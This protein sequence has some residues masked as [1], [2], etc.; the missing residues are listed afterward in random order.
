MHPE[1]TESSAFFQQV[2]DTLRAEI[3]AAWQAWKQ[4]EQERWTQWEKIVRKAIQVHGDA[5]TLLERGDPWGYVTRVETQVL[6]P[7]FAALHER[8]LP[9][10][11]PPTPSFDTLDPD[12]WPERV[13]VPLEAEVFEKETTGWF[14]HRLLCRIARGVITRWNR[15]WPHRPWT[16]RIPL[17]KLLAFHLEV[18]VPCAWWPVY[19]ICRTHW[20]RSVG[21]IEE[22]LTVWQEKVLSS[23]LI[24]GEGTPGEVLEGARAWQE[25]LIAAIQDPFPEL[26]IP[27]T[28]LSEELAR[29]LDR[30][31]TFLL[32]GF[33][34]RLPRKNRRFHGR[35]KGMEDAW[36]QWFQQTADRVALVAGRVQVALALKTQRDR[37]VDRLKETLRTPY[38]CVVERFRN[39]LHQM[40]KQWTRALSDP[41]NDPEKLDSHVKEAL[42]TREGL[43]EILLG[44]LDLKQ[45]NAVLDVPA[46]REWAEVVAVLESLPEQ[47]VLHSAD[48][49]RPG[50][51]FQTLM[52]R[53]LILEHI[54]PPWP[55]RLETPSSHLRRAILRS[56]SAL[57][58]ILE[59]VGYNLEAAREEIETG[60]PPENLRSRLEELVLGSLQSAE[61]RLDEST[62]EMDETLRAFL[63]TLNRQIQ[64]DAL[65]LEQRFRIELGQKS[66]WKRLRMRVSHR[67]DQWLRR[68]HELRKRVDKTLETSS[69]QTLRKIHYLVRRGQAVMGMSEPE[70][71]EP[72]RAA[73]ALLGIEHVRA[74][75]PLVYRRLFTFDP[76]DD[77]A[78]LVGRD[79]ELRQIMAWY[80]RWRRGRGSGAVVVT[81]FPGTGLTS[82]LNVLAVTVF[83]DALVHRLTLHER[84][85]DEGRLSFLLAQALQLPE[86]PNTLDG[87][88]TTIRKHLDHTKPAVM[89]IDNL[90]HVLL[91]AY[92]GQALLERLLMLFVRTD[93]H[94]FWIAGI[95]RPAWF[96]FERMARNAVGLVQVLTLR[97]PDR[98]QLERAIEIRHLRSGLPLRFE[99]PARPSPVLRQRLRR[100]RTPEMQQ[101][102]LREAFFNRL[103]EEARSNWRLAFLYW[104]RSVQVDEGGL[105]VRAFIPLTF[106]FL[107]QLTLDQA[108]TLKALLRHRT[109]TLEEHQ[110][111]FRTMPV[112]SLFVL[113]SLLN[114]RLIEPV[115]DT[116]EEGVP[117]YV[118]YRLVPFF[119]EPVR[120]ELRNRHVLYE[121]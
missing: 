113:E 49:H 30:A 110:K 95:S 109:L 66:L 76:L 62:R 87:V 68:V 119:V 99:P 5:M 80:N 94:I 91:C 56:W 118:R 102:V 57:E 78:L 15:R 19:E 100:A 24:D 71:V 22:G 65:A 114:Q 1:I 47:C 67:T 90:E 26:S 6:R 7:L 39:N 60:G 121:D 120:R 2:V 86:A 59:I 43:R 17:Q 20:A 106:E 50:G 116:Q 46:D 98:A 105:R 63:D 55:E 104:L 79:T 88:E 111:L 23:L 82:T 42:D 9:Q 12:R 77:P 10:G 14:G 45:V 11:V 29:D 48:S 72:M 89:L 27:E 83:A 64:K 44:H 34:R 31:G 41:G 108:F 75:L 4:N 25:A 73:D 33:E 51:P 61:K 93:R 84:V 117:S 52:L 8:V 70:T 32:W 58:E 36:Q 74:R 69:Q 16:R 97:E 103:Y 38:L 53:R 37:F 35:W 85:Q 92:G 112:Q 40:Q 101:A 18:R 115:N 81:A 107:E 21:R 13:R 54:R 96:F 3:G 28:S